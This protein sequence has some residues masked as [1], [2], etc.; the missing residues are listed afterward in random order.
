MASQEQSQKVLQPNLSVA[1]PGEPEIYN[2]KEPEA[3]KESLKFVEAKRSTK[4][5]VVTQTS[6][7]YQQVLKYPIV[8]EAAIKLISQENTLVFMVDIRADKKDIRN[9]FENM[10]K[11]KTKKINTL[12]NHDGTKKAF[13]QLSSDNQ[14]ATVAKKLKILG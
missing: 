3:E 10:L 12:I 8:T 5:K 11:I 7:D 2:F 4:E 6:M 9:A 13:I 1:A 14:A